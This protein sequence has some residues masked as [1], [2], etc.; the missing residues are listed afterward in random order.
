MSLSNQTIN[1]LL[2][3][4]KS[5]YM[6]KNSESNK[7]FKYI[8]GDSVV[9]K[10]I[11]VENQNT[12]DYYSKIS[13]NDHTLVLDSES[14]S[15][16]GSIEPIDNL[17]VSG[18][19]NVSNINCSGTFA[20]NGLSVNGTVSADSFLSLSQFQGFPQNTLSLIPLGFT[21]GGAFS[22]LY[23]GGCLAPN[24]K[25]Y[26][27]PGT[28]NIPVL[29]INPSNDTFTTID[30]TTIS[31]GWRGGVL[32]KNGKIYCAPSVNLKIL[33][34]DTNNNTL[35][36][37]D[38]P[39]PIYKTS[40]LY[41][42]AAYANDKVIF[43]PF[44]AYQ[45]LVIDIEQNENLPFYPVGLAPPNPLPPPP[46]IPSTNPW[47]ASQQSNFWAGAVLGIDGNIYTVPHNQVN[48]S[49][50]LRINPYTLTYTVAVNSAASSGEFFLFGGG[51]L[52]PNGEI[53]LMPRRGINN[54]KKI[55][56]LGPAGV[57]NTITALDPAFNIPS[58]SWNTVLYGGIL[59][60]NGSIYCIPGTSRVIGNINSNGVIGNAIDVTSLYQAPD[61]N[62]P[63]YRLWFGGVCGP[64]SKIYLM[65]WSTPNIGVIKTGL[66]TIS[67][68][69]LYPQFNKF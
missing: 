14:I 53:Y 13:C 39:E 20:G 24:G 33:V 6:S 32:A 34:I 18:T 66:P 40:N 23:Q 27:I 63:N 62:N 64:N 26:G 25:I 2:N 7:L 47:G 37:L 22:N 17:T 55:Y 49:S 51:V 48:V 57:Y 59:S 61:N 28:N 5:V 8:G 52:H 69:N 44:D 45:F 19:L 11:Y 68:W 67:N 9:Y 30:R 12:G 16:S 60:Q 43:I 3:S 29:V 41:W 46:T 38:V 4:K 65:P 42:G 15:L 54:N 56:K 50:I 35:S 31:G 21:Q 58:S 36:T 10:N 1:N